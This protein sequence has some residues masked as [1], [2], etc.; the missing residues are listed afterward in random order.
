[1]RRRW[2]SMYGAKPDEPDDAP[3]TM[4][5]TIPGEDTGVDDADDLFKIATGSSSIDFSAQQSIWDLDQLD[6]LDWLERPCETPA[7]VG[8]ALAGDKDGKVMFVDKSASAA[9]AEPTRFEKVAAVAPP[10]VVSEALRLTDKKPLLFPWEKG[11]LGRIFG[12]QGRLSLKQPKLNPGANNFVQVGVGVSEGFHVDGALTVRAGSKDPTLYKAV[13]KNIIGC[14]Y[15]EEREAQRDHAVRQWWD[16]LRFNMAASDPGQAAVHETGLSDIYKYGIELLD[17][18]FGIKSPGTLMKRLCAIKLYNH[19][20]IRHYSEVWIPLSEQRV[21]E[22]MR[23]LRETKAPAPRAV[24]LLESVRFCHHLLKVDGAHE[25]LDSLRVK[26]LAAQLYAS[27]KPWH[28]SDVLSV[29][30]VEFLHHCFMDVSLCD[31]DRIFVGDLLHMLYARAR[32]SD[33]L[34]VTDLFIDDENAFMEVSA[35]LHKGARS[36]DARSKLLP[37]V[38]PATGIVGDNWARTY[39]ELRHKAGL[40]NPKDVACPMLLAPKPGGQGWSDRYVTSQ[41]LNSFIKK[42]FANGGRSIAGRK[43]TTHSMKATGL[44]WCS[45]LGISQEHRSILAR[46]ATSVQGATVLYSRDLLS[47]AMRSFNSVLSSIRAQTFQPD[48]SRSGM[49]TPARATP[50]GAPV[51]P[52]PPVATAFPAVAPLVQ[53]NVDLDAGAGAEGDAGID[54]AGTTEK[55]PDGEL[56]SP[57]TPLVKEEFEWPTSD[58][59]DGVIDLEEQHDLLSAWQSGSEEESSGCSDSDE[60]SSFEWDMPMPDESPAVH[61][62]AIVPKWHINVKT[63][64]IHETRNDSSFR[65]G[66]ALSPMYVAIPALTGLRC[67]KCFAHC[68]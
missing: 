28:P 60:S 52:F 2:Q 26:G 33:L 8:P 6:A 7:P 61:P 10:G 48:K 29:S 3:T 38:A 65:C 64:V 9:A 53:S 24:S 56:Y 17:A 40:M 31:V 14:T 62:V 36:M 4:P 27:K 63:N 49:I 5:V 42:L 66:R 18:V 25:T 44:S 16:L 37:I 59:N 23:F 20:I 51:T 54:V 39:L 57:G 47:S 19:W 50:A 22:Y 43:I 67:G 58:W 12:Q 45:K 13:V 15:T 11:R 68:L 46:H 21:W 34:S 35:T 30:E 32:F 1:M 55:A 41:E